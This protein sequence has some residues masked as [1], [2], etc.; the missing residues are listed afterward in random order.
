MESQ[1]PNG[2]RWCIF[3]TGVHNQH[4]LALLCCS[5]FTI[6]RF[7]VLRT[8]CSSGAH[9]AIEALQEGPI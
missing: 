3:D 5:G 6:Q 9:L 7:T 4:Q 1:L 8:N 2:M